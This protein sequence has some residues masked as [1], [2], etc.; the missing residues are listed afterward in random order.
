LLLLFSVGGPEIGAP[1]SAREVTLKASVNREAAAICYKTHDNT[2][3]NTLPMGH[4]KTQLRRT[5]TL[6]ASARSGISTPSEAP[7]LSI[8]GVT[9]D[10]MDDV[11]QQGKTNTKDGV[12]K[13]SNCRKGLE[14]SDCANDVKS[15]N[16][17]SEQ[18]PDDLSE[19]D[20]SH[21]DD[22]DDDDEESES[23][24]G[25]SE[26]FSN[27]VFSSSFVISGA[28]TSVE[29]NTT[30]T[31]NGDA[32]SDELTKKG[33][34]SWNKTEKKCSTTSTSS[35]A[36]AKWNNPTHQSYQQNRKES[37]KSRNESNKSNKGS[38]RSERKKEKTKSS[39]LN[40][41]LRT[42]S[43]C[44]HRQ[45]APSG[46][47]HV[48]SGSR[49]TS[50]RRHHRHGGARKGGK[51]RA[52]SVSAHTKRMRSKTTLMMFVLTICYV[53]NWLPHLVVRSVDLLTGCIYWLS[54]DIS[55]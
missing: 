34:F 5:Q 2:A 6:P 10:A 53:I 28:T 46:G 50:E 26:E 37:S 24:Q 38:A 40:S 9:S 13:S 35:A 18:Y 19:S 16:D 44:L 51:F 31:E 54:L 8:K 14:Q 41:K 17:G 36:Q 27:S 52:P 48:T 33:I 12:D 30:K 42:L 3:S 4:Q 49:V 11:R 43:L 39:T 45:V 1:Q 55:S 47:H 23:W 29:F 22:D 21:Y 7:A 15:E 25:R 20:N 32:D